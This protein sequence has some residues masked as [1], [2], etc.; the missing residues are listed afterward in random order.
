MSSKTKK[1]DRKLVTALSHDLRPDGFSKMSPQDLIRHANDH[2]EFIYFGSRIN[3]ST[4][5][6]MFH[7]SVCIRFPA[8]E[9]ILDPYEENIQGCT[10]G[11]PIHILTEEQK[12]REWTLTPTSFESVR[13]EARSLITQYAFPFF[14]EFK[15]IED[16]AKH[17]SPEKN[18]HWSILDQTRQIQIFAAS[19]CVLHRRTEAVALL[20]EEIEK[21]EKEME[22]N[23]PRLF[24]YRFPLQQLLQ[25]LTSVDPNS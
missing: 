18:P 23:R 6:E 17:L 22:N 11:S 14:E 9:A 21:L 12:F 19:L 7:F 2:S 25:R 5:L 1:L 24:K 16:V 8:I 10:F 4:R 15:S 13:S 3:R 20:K